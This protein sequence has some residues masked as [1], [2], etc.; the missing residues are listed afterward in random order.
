M[1]SGV[2]GHVGRLRMY[3]VS[4]TQ[5]T[6]R[7]GTPGDEDAVR[8]TRAKTI[9]VAA[10]LLDRAD[11]YETESPCWVALADAAENILVGEVA[12]A[13]ECGELDG[14]LYDRLRTMQRCARAVDPSLGVAD[15]ERGAK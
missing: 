5:G 11:R 7:A 10:Y 9:D 14:S 3:T 2:A 1:H 13:V 6:C 4:K 15:H 8:K 12:R